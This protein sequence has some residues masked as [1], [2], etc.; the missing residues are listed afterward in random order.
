MAYMEGLLHA[1]DEYG[2]G[3]VPIQ[4]KIKY[5]CKVCILIPV[6]TCRYARIG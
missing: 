1:C 5:V 6:T 2:G 3:G 4:G